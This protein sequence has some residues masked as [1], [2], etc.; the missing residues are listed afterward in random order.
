MC[1]W[2]ESGAEST[3]FRIDFRLD[4]NVFSHCSQRFTGTQYHLDSVS[5][6]VIIFS[7]SYY[8]S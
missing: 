1:G 6:N 7:Y 5:R 2:T 8:Y 3:E 4:K